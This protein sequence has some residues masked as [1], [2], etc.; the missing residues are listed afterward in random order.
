MFK[1]IEVNDGSNPKRYRILHVQLNHYACLWRAGVP[2]DSC[3]FAGVKE[4]DRDLY[5]V[6]T[7]VNLELVFTLP[8]K[9]AIKGENGKFLGAYLKDGRPYLQFSYDNQNDPRVLH[10]M[11]SSPDGIVCIKCIHFG[12]FWRLGD[13][14]WIVADADDPRGSINAA[15]MFRA[16]NIEVNEI[17][18]LNMS[19]TWYCKRLTSSLESC[20][21]CASQNVDKG[22]TLK[23]IEL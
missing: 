21:N 22:S 2:F 7:F 14:D 20:L 3:L 16:T 23:L 8:K 4:I 1:R 19:K 18:L 15:A 17:A 5:D 10:E 6:F 12:K 13:G 11:I 9:V